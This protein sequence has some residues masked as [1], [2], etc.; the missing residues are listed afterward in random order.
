MRIQAISKQAARG[1]F[2]AT[3]MAVASVAGPVSA[4]SSE[5]IKIPI[6]NWSSQIV[7]AHVI[8]GMF[9]EMG[10][11]VEY[12]PVD[13]QAA[14][15]AIR[16]GDLTIG[17]EV[18]QATHQ[19]AFYNAM[20]KG[21]LIDAGTHAAE[22]L[23]EMGVPNWVIEQ[24]L[25]PGLPNWEALK[26]CHENFATPDSGG[27]GRW[28]EGPQSW[29]GDV[30]PNRLK[31]LGLDDK[32]MVKFAG[33]GDALWVELEAA[34]KEGR[35]TIIF[36]WTPNFTD[37]EGFTFIEFPPYFD[38]CRIID[39]GDMST[40]GCGSPRGW[41]KKA[42]NFRFPVTHPQAYA[43]FTKVSFTTDQIG[44]MAALVDQDKMTHE[45]A[46]KKWLA[47]NEEVWKPWTASVLD[48]A[49]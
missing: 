34:K 20:E 46:A 41:L 49:N 45:D 14:F 13:N 40:T 38:G 1:L 11:R 48:G 3:A 15:E 27:K 18:W 5:P 28:L 12:V 22:T 10:S 6:K 25:C 47:D 7:M 37:A 23:E 36:N 2:A 8:G 16:N 9:E 39:G 44:T 29:H 42:A 31:G 33:T 24:D 21:G 32:W 17:H 26:D 35:G 43:A 30:M 4:D 19:N